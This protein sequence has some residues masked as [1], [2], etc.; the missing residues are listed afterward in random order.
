MTDN[1]T[2]VLSFLGGMSQ[3]TLVMFLVIIAGSVFSFVRFETHATDMETYNE[4]RFES[5]EADISELTTRVRP[6]ELEI[7]DIK[8]R[9]SHIEDEI[10]DISDKIDILVARR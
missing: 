8:A 4:R 1:R 3:Q 5:I 2:G 9:L 10:S 6:I 7:V